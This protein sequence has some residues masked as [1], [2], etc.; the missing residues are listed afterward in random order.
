M[1]YVHAFF[2]GLGLAA[3]IGSIVAKKGS[4]IHKKMGKLFSAGMLISSTISIPIAWMPNHKNLFLFLIGLFTIYLV[5]SGNRALK[6][7]HKNKPQAMDKVISGG[8]FIFSVIM[9]SIGGFNLTS[10]LNTG[11]LY[12]FF[13]GFGLFFA[14]IDFRFFIDPKR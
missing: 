2:G 3:G 6:Y 12:L 4:G 7:R 10:H 11:L 13:G 14:I 9:V 1:I 5:L 8:M